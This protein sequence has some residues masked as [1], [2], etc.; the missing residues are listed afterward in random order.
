MDEWYFED[1]TREQFLGFCNDLFTW[2]ESID[3]RDLSNITSYHL[4]DSSCMAYLSEQLLKLI[5]MG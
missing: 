2:D 5:N 4:D 3:E 1:W